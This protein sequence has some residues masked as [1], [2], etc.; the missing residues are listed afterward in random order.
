MIKNLKIVLFVM[1]LALCIHGAFQLSGDRVSWYTLKS[2][3]C[4]LV[5]EIRIF[6][7][8]NIKP[9]RTHFEFHPGDLIFTRRTGYLSNIFIPG[10][11]T[12]AA[13][14]LG[15]SGE[16]ISCFSDCPAIDQIDGSQGWV[17]EALNQGV[18]IQPTAQVLDADKVLVLRPS[19]SNQ[20]K[21]GVITKALQLLGKPYDYNFDFAT[22]DKI[23]CSELIWHSYAG[24]L[25]F[26]IHQLLGKSFS[27]PDEMVNDFLTDQ[28]IEKV[29]VKDQYTQSF[30]FR[31][32]K[33]DISKTENNLIFSLLVTNFQFT[34]N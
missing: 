1:S 22:A 10:Y 24:E 8:S 12:H 2:K 28:Q 21:L 26:K 31:N 3:T 5:S 19:I 6:E 34:K 14:Y 20:K 32:N 11:Y 15:T 17:I 27:T 7:S 4:A 18:A 25:E 23:S 16:M 13:L 30:N 29:F 33:H 9:A